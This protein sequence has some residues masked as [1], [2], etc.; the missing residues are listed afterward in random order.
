MYIFHF[1]C[2]SKIIIRTYIVEY[3]KCA[4]YINS[5]SFKLKLYT[6][7]ISIIVILMRKSRIIKNWSRW[8]KQKEIKNDANSPY[9]L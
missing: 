1:I 9:A 3:L 8:Y 5:A 7:G 4:N 6:E 2:F